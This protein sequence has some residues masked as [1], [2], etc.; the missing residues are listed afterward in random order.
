MKFRVNY[1]LVCSG[2]VEVEADN[3]DG[4]IEAVTCMDLYDLSKTVEPEEVAVDTVDEV[5]GD[6]GQA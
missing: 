2:S 1:Q 4:A 5:G 6:H 3:E